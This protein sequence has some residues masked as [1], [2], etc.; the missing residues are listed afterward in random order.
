MLIKNVSSRPWTIGATR[1]IPGETVEVDC[2]KED[3]GDN[4]DLKVVKSIAK[5]EPEA[6][7]KTEIKAK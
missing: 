5:V 6:E 7:V 1:I 3:I 4:P 2:A